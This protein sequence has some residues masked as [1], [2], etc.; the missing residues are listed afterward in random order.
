MNILKYVSLLIISSLFFQSCEKPLTSGEADF[1]KGCFKDSHISSLNECINF[2][3]ILL[4][5]YYQTGKRSENYQ[6][7]V[8]TISDRNQE[9]SP[10]FDKRVKKQFNL[11]RDNRL[12]FE[13]F[14]MYELNYLSHRAAANQSMFYIYM[15]DVENP[16]FKC[17]HS[18]VKHPIIKAYLEHYK[19]VDAIDPNT[20][21]W[22]EIDNMKVMLDTEDYNEPDIRMYIAVYSLFHMSFMANPEMMVGLE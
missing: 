7:F 1:L 12:F 5:D 9:D 2:V 16:F 3:D 18:H 19:H 4:E 14:T 10:L 6:K 22:Y 11:M 20:N 13:I 17:W 15:I 8:E 21:F